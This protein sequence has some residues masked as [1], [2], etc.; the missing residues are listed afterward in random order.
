MMPQIMRSGAVILLALLLTGCM[1]M[2]MRDPLQIAVAGIEPLPS[3]GMEL[4]LLVKL[5]VQNPNDVAIDYNGVALQMLVLGKTFATGVSDE[6]GTVPRFGESVVS[7]PIT[8]SAFNMVLQA[9]GVVS[10]KRIERIDY[11]MKGKLN[12][13]AFSSVR[14]DTAGSFDLPA[15]AN[16]PR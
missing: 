9:L 13:P 14:F 10:G 1:S 6:A 11:E 3:E 7:V 12:R 4:R 15:S 8:A 2:Q 5:R 16:A